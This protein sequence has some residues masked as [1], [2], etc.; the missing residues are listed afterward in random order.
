MPKHYN[1]TS[2][3]S[4]EEILKIINKSTPKETE[5]L[6]QMVL[7]SVSKEDLEKVMALHRAKASRDEARILGMPLVH[8]PR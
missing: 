8:G 4:T 2:G 7:D 1:E 5:E 6:Y 3:N